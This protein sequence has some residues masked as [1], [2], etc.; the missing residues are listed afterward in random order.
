MICSTKQATSLLLRHRGPPLSPSLISGPCFRTR[1][2]LNPTGCLSPWWRTDVCEGRGLAV[3]QYD[4]NCRRESRLHITWEYEDAF[5]KQAHCGAQTY[6]L[7]QYLVISLPQRLTNVTSYYLSI[8]IKYTHMT[9]YTSVF[10]IQCFPWGK[11][12]LWCLRLKARVT[13]M[14]SFQHARGKNS[15]MIYSAYQ[16]HSCLMSYCWSAELW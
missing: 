5:S 4:E 8:S 10:F 1:I 12:W 15:G 13:H 7:Q 2:H 6:Q 11:S 16:S 14:N 3:F 9:T